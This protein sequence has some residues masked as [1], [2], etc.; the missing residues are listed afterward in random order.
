MIN[1]EELLSTLLHNRG[2]KKEEIEKF[3]NPKYEDMHDPFLL[4]SMETACVRIYEAIEAKEKI[5]IYSDYDCDGIPS[6]VIMHDFFRKINYENFVVYIPDRHD[7]GY[8]LHLD[9][10]DG[11]IKENVKLIITFDLGITAIK[12]VAHAK[13][14]GIDTIIVDHHLPKKTVNEN[15]EI[16]DDLPRAYAIIDHMQNI[17]SYPEQI[18]CGAG[19]AFKLIQALCL[20]YGEYWKINKDWE[21]WLLDL[22]S[23]A[24]LS[25]QVPLLGENRIIAYFG[26]KVL[27]KG[28]RLGLVEVFKKAKVDI[29]TLSEEDVT[30]TL[31]PRINASSRMGSPMSAYK[32]LSTRD[33]IEARTLSDHLDDI[34]TDRKYIVSNIMKEVKKTMS[35]REE[36]EIIVIG[37]PSW[38]VGVLGIV[39]SKITE[40]YKKPAFVWGREGGDTI[41]GSAR[42]YNNVHLVELMSQTKESF[43]TFGGHHLAGGF[44]VSEDMIHKL[45][46][47]LLSAHEF[48]LNNKKETIVSDDINN[49]VDAILTLDD[50]NN[51]NYS[52]IE[53]LSP[54]G[55]GNKKPIFKFEKVTIKEVKEFGKDK[56][57]LEIILLNTMSRPVKAIAFYK[58]RESFNIKINDQID[59]FAH[60]EKNTFAGRTELR[61]RIVDIV[62]L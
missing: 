22:S 15:G 16:I 59:L 23:I 35:K 21:K 39:A 8:G 52:V 3:L 36:K 37:S 53:K 46:E 17:C 26:L 14:N 62:L 29:R 33:P 40:E 9:S 55:V 34:N 27:Q 25:D 19:L 11:F 12:E 4:F 7:E 48:I 10:I 45:E 44:E 24:T 6:A 57:H 32:L 30:F 58:T 20:K 54:Y 56:N 60:F 61:L 49:Q 31:S 18:L 47:D 42:S 5:V 50:V 43:V 38:R 1:S 41:R 51:E 13:V 28:A 2:V